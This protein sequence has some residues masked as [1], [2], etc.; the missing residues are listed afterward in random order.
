MSTNKSMSTPD[1]PF[2]EEQIWMIRRVAAPLLIVIGAAPMVFL[3]SQAVYFYLQGYTEIYLHWVVLPWGFA[4]M[5]AVLGG[6]GIRLHRK[7]QEEAAAA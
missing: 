5:G 7:N 1:C 6:E 4:L 2:T 3:L